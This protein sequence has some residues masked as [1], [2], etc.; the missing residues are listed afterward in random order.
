MEQVSM[1][2]GLDSRETLAFGLAAG[3]VAVCVLALLSGYTV[4][5]SGLP[6]AVG[7]TLALLLVGAGAVLSWGRLAGRPMVEWA[8]LL[9]GFVIRTRHIRVARARERAGRWSATTRAAASAA[10]VRMAARSPSSRRDLHSGDVVIP[11]ALRRLEPVGGAGSVARRAQGRSHVVGFFSLAGGTGRTTLAVEV[12]ALLAVR[13]R[14][15]GATGSTGLRVALLDLAR[16][17]PCVGLR[18]GMPAPPRPRLLAHE[19]GLLVGLAPATLPADLGGAPASPQLVDSLERA[20]VDIVIV[21]FDC[22]L[23]ELCGALLERCDQVLVTMTP[24]AGGVVDAYRSTALL[25]RLGLRDR[26]GHVVNRWRPGVDLGEVMGDLA[27]T[28]VAQ[29]PDDR[30]LTDAENNH[31]LAGLEGEG[32]VVAALALLAT[33]IEEAAAAGRSAAGTPRWGRHA[34]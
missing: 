14:A 3:E 23:G 33:R 22:D 31:R 18:L 28:I 8:V 32:D 20:A 5:R 29:I 16:R 30:A 26:I 7:W 25:R 24:T 11:L 19:T 15:A 10:R 27:G 9:A 4:L 2:D 34:G 21:D 12:A 13:E 17:N 1:N 6:G